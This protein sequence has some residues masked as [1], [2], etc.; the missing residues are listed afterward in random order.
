MATLSQ[1][2]AAFVLNHSGII[3]HQ[4]DTIYGL[5][6]LPE[7]ALLNR[8]SFIKNRPKS[9]PFILLASHI[10]QVIN[11]IETDTHSIETLATQTE[12]PTTWLVKAAKNISPQLVGKDNKIAIRLT[13]FPAIKTI[14]D[15]VGAIAST[16]ANISNYPV[17]T[18]VK[19]IRDTF[20][21][22]I[23]YV[24]QNQTPGSGKSST[25]VDLSSGDIIRR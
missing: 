6:C 25:I 18:N 24:D 1:H 5:A 11:Y 10:D 17:C 7:D 4:T 20:G 2:Q 23:D 19:Q 12:S 16:S 15:Q 22:N 3:A 14:C 8:L 9:K 13:N 21:P